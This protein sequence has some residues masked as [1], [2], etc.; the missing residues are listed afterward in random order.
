MPFR[1]ANLFREVEIHSRTKR[2]VLGGQTCNVAN[3]CA[4]PLSAGVLSSRL[5]RLPPLQSRKVRENRSGGKSKR[6]R[7]E[8]Q[9]ERRAPVERGDRPLRAEPRTSHRRG[10][11]DFGK[12]GQNY[13]RGQR[14]RK[15][16]DFDAPRGERGARGDQRGNKTSSEGPKPRRPGKLVAD[17][18]QE[19]RGARGKYPGKSFGK[20]KKF[21][22]GGK[23]PKT[24]FGKRVKK[25]NR[26]G[27]SGG[28][29][30]S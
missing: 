28:S 30:R 22:G 16:E 10:K 3:S 6:P 14:H 24:I 15:P 2:N 18:P 8:P 1:V 20:G 25:K 17:R 9:S 29:T 12:P 19:D 13:R 27:S 26:G 4:P 11:D 5:V 7:R 23:G 21:A